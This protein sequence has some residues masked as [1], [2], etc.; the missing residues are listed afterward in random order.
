[1]IFPGID[2]LSPAQ[3]TLLTRDGWHEEV[4]TLRDSTNWKLIL[5]FVNSTWSLTALPYPRDRKLS[6]DAKAMLVE[7]VTAI[8][9]SPPDTEPLR[10]GR[11]W[12]DHP[13]TSAT[14][15]WRWRWRW[16]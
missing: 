12:G 15:A 13:G 2:T 16:S 9:G 8:I 5:Q 6:D 3:D 10:V 11:P 4:V 1:M 14:T 7:A